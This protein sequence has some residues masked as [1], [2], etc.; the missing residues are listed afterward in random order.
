MALL[1][2]AL[3]SG[4]WIRPARAPAQISRDNTLVV[5]VFRPDGVIV[6]FALYAKRRWTNPWHT[7]VPDAPLDEPDTIAD[8]PKP[9]YESFVKPGA[10]WYLSLSS[11]D[12]NAVRTSRNIQV[13]SHCQQVWGLLTDYPKAKP[14]EKNDCVRNLGIALSLKKQTRPIE[15]PTNTSPDA[16]QLLTFLIPEFE[17]AESAGL[18]TEQARYYAAQMPPAQE[19]AKVPLSLTHLYQTK[20]TDEGPVLSYFEGSK[21]YAKPR[22][23]NDAGCNNV[24]LFGGWVRRDARGKFLLLD[25][26]FAPTDCDMKEGDLSL[27]LAI[28]QM[29]GKTFAIVEEDSYEGEGYV[30][31]EIRKDKVRR[32]LETLAGSC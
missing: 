26:Q 32:I 31:L 18:A 8:L 23:A 24:S 25:S 21:E 3:S 15:Q 11:A 17:R 19:R 22:A 5:G 29:D 28:L 14:P 4:G 2:T 7:P 13:C 30:I 10:E 12:A 27:P 16:K 9:W 6:P 20:L 1:A